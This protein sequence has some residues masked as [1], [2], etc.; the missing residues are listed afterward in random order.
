MRNLNFSLAAVMLVLA[1]FSCQNT[2]L[3][4]SLV[5]RSTQPALVQQAS[6]ASAL[7]TY[8]QSHYRQVFDEHD[9]NHNGLIEAREIP[10]A[11]QT[12]AKLDLNHDGALSPSE[13]LPASE[14]LSQATGALSKE[15]HQ[16]FASKPVAT[17]DPQLTLP[18]ENNYAGFENAFLNQVDS[19][20]SQALV[21]QAPQQ[22]VGAPVLLVPG[23]AEPS[24]Y[25]MYG[26]YKDL[27][28]AGYAVEGINLFPNFATAEEQAL[29][30]KAKIEAMMK[31]YG[32]S[33]IN[34][35]VHS[36]GGLISRY[37][38]QNL[39]GSR[40]VDNLVTVTTPHL[41]TYAAYLGPGA[42]AVQLRPESEFIQK[43]NAN[44]FAYPPVKYTSIWTNL[45]EIVLPPKNSIMP[46][47]QVFY[48]P[49]TGHLTVMFS[50]RTYGY[51]R[52]ALK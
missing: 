11:A 15:L 46:D 3:Q 14:A 40:V 4:G 17:E 23:Y 32:S 7:G 50:Q 41:G 52:Q 6:T 48:V 19:L 24:W 51:I 8:L 18:Q 47:S 13:V 38:I 29:K 2:A 49:W 10:Y 43:L 16:A 44:G 37:Y 22:Y 35:V 9:S 31:H 21:P 28:K 36:F 1:L 42:S 30:V 45:D 26:I 25:F 34:L 20:R 27:K 12:F 39:G 5:A 33:K